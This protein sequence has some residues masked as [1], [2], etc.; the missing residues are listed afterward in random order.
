MK[1][2]LESAAF[3]SVMIVLRAISKIEIIFKKRNHRVARRG[4]ERWNVWRR[5][6]L[7]AREKRF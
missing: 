1:R 5:M 6:R 4:D 3:A 7:E 2:A